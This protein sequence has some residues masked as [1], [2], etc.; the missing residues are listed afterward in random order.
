MGAPTAPPASLPP[1]ALLGVGVVCCTNAGSSQRSR[2][3]DSGGAA[4]SGGG[5]AGSG[6]RG[7]DDERFHALLG[8]SRARA[9]A[10]LERDAC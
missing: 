4:A 2:R 8:G 1:C 5:A 6:G 3:D 9:R 7:G 10:S